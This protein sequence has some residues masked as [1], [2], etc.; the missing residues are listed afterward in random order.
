MND[1]KIGAYTIHNAPDYAEDSPF[2]VVRSVDDTG[3]WFYGAYD[4]IKQAYDVAHQVHGEVIC[5]L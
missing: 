5:N 4:N 3:L 2:I 1:L